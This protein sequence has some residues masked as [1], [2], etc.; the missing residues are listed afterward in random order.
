MYFNLR[1]I[2]F[3]QTDSY[4]D[5]LGN[6]I[7]V[8]QDDLG[9]KYEQWRNQSQGTPWIP[10]ISESNYKINKILFYNSVYGTLPQQ[11]V[12][13]IRQGFRC[14]DLEKYGGR[15]RLEIYD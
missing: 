5:E 8:F 6:L 13:E 9:I 12:D 15:M 11:Y 2:S 3:D 14:E 1:K 4:F 7:P 10:C